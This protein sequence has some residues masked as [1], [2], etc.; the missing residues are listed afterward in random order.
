VRARLRRGGTLSFQERLLNWAYEAAWLPALNASPVVAREMVRAMQMREVS[1]L[2]VRIA[3][4]FELLRAL[5]RGWFSKE[6][7]PQ[8]AAPPRSEFLRGLPE[9][10]PSAALE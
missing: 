2:G 3:V 1:E 6:T 7:P 8:L 4:G 9:H 5:I 10:Q